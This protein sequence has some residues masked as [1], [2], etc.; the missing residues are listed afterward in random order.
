VTRKRRSLSPA[1]IACRFVGEQPLGCPSTDVDLWADDVLLDPY[2][3]FAELRELGPVVWLERYGAVALPRFEQVSAALA[4][5]RRFSSARGV[6]IDDQLNS[7]L[8]ENAIAS[9]PPA[10]DQFRK[11][12]VDQLWPEGLGPS[13]PAVEATALRFADEAV[14]AGCFDAVADLCRPYSLA[15]VG[16]LLGLPE[17]ERSDYPVLAE[18]AFNVFGPAGDRA[19][20]GFQAAAELVSRALNSDAPGA[21]IPGRRGR[22]LWAIGMPSL[23]VSYTWPGIDTTVNAL[24]SAVLLFARHPD[25]WSEL[26]AD[27]SLI[28]SAFN[29]V[30]RLHSPVHFFTRS[31]NEPGK[32]GGV[33]LTVGTKVLLMYGS[34]NRDERRF[35]KPDTF[36]IHRAGRSHL[37]F[38][39]GVHLCAGMH[40]ARLEAHSLLDALADRVAR[41]ELTTEPTWTVNHTLHGLATLPV[42][43]AP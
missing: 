19:T 17:E 39:R 32:V 5:W 36:D 42:R 29:E 3:V 21:L 33:E 41:F 28:P 40:L 22:Q 35:E 11:P 34:A 31:V 25:A 26:R 20:D 15:V 24:A 6:G 27:R 2:P 23:I 16:D 1:E 43:A 9:D 13:V 4:D 30:L 8:G 12:L 7:F 14:R 37:A 38:G 10:H 18:R